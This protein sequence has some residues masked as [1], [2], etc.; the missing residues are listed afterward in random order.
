MAD[1]AGASVID[2]STPSL[3]P[4]PPRRV[5]VRTLALVVLAALGVVLLLRSAREVFIPLALGLLVSYALEPLVSPLARLVG[6]GVAAALVVVTVTSGLGA[7][8]YGLQTEV[9]AIVDELPEA[10]A[11]LRGTLRRDRG[12]TALG[13]VQEAVSEIEKTATVAAGPGAPAPPAPRLDVRGYLVWGSLGIVGMLAQG[14]MFV[15]L[16]F[17]LLLTGDLYKRKLVHLAGPSLSRQKRAV[18]VCDEIGA[19]MRRFLL[20]EAA[21]AVI[22]G[23]VTWLA[24]WWLGVANAGVWGVAAGALNSIPYFGPV[25]V[26]AGLAVVAFLQFGSTGKMLSV[27]GVSL[28]ITSV[29][30]WLLRPALLGRAAQMSHLAV[31]VGLLFFGWLWGVVGVLLA[32]PM[33]TMLKAVCDRVDGLRPLGELMGE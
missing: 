6:R 15:F 29:E 11:R 22:V 30:G 10:A 21:T 27:I 2:E 1:S 12:E 17:F 5:D 19:Q 32:V 13:K 7:L 16:V 4:L 23:L 33:M 24:L 26:G 31:F 20:V 18:Q 8:A 3:E 25:L 9:L 14:V 28:A